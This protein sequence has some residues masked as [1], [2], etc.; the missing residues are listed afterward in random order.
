MKG[1]DSG[2]RLGTGTGGKQPYLVPHRLLAKKG[3]ICLLHPL[4]RLVGPVAHA[5][6]LWAWSRHLYGEET[7]VK[8][9]GG[10]LRSYDGGRMDRGRPCFKAQGSIPAPSFMLCL[11]HPSSISASSPSS[12]LGPCH[13]LWGS[14]A[15][16][17]LD[18]IQCPDQSLWPAQG[19][20][21]F[22]GGSK[23]VMVT[24][25]S[26]FQTVYNCPHR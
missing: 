21:H 1:Q 15:F 22:P 4:G 8:R 20:S 2:A 11:K 18:C 26:Q 23:E 25:P 24:T 7:Q 19:G 3:N 13:S 12:L 10:W 5:G 17:S 6:S 16:R 9:L 14:R